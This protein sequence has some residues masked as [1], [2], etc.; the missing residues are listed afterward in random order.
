V[1]ARFNHAQILQALHRDE[2][3]IA[4]YRV[5]LAQRP[6]FAAA[7]LGLGTAL[8][9]EGRIADAIVEFREALRLKPGDV[10]ARRNL[11]MAE[12]MLRDKSR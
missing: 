3:A 11:A 7:H 8:G 4:E 9:D 1:D 5:V 6:G 10:D 2:E 12:Q